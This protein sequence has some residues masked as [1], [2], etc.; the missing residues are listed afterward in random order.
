MSKG[1]ILSA[2]RSE[3]DPVKKVAYNL[4]ARNALKKAGGKII[5]IAKVGKN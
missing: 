2:Q 3:A 4:L 5:A 1:Y